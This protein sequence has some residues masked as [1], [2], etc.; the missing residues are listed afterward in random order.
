MTKPIIVTTSWD[1][2]DR[3]DLRIA[4]LLQAHGMQGTFYVPIKPF[5]A[6][7]AL[8]PDN[9]R[10]M[11]AQGFEI[12]G[13]GIAHENMSS[14]SREEAIEVARTCKRTLEDT[15]AD[16]LRMFCYPNG[17][18]SAKVVE[19]LRSAGYQ[20]ART[21]R[22][23]ATEMDCGPFDLPTS[24]QVY[25]HTRIEYLRN[26]ARSHNPG[27][28]Y[29]YVTSLSLDDDWME[30]GKKLFNRV[31]ANGGIWHLWG[32]SWEIQDMGL[33]EQLQEM[34]DYVARRDSVLYL[35]NGDVLGYLPAYASVN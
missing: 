24:T 33:W 12:G 19:A 28:L 16:E 6:N 30:I 10:S 9:L 8:S 25:P 27:R 15:V 29:D 2:G 31:L 17:R 32:H 22:L 1:D 4:E 21:I 11:H 35:T 23:L 5:N 34:L 18:Y 20:G 13:H 26:I 7:P 14:L 3:H